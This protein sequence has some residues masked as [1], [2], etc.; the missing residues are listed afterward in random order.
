M[1][2]WELMEGMSNQ[3][4]VHIGLPKTATTSLQLDFFPHVD[5]KEFKYLGVFQFREQRVQDV[6]FQKII[7]AVRSGHDL[8]GANRAL[9]KRLEEEKRS[10][11][12]S[13]E[14]LT[15]GSELKTWQ[16]QLANLSQILAGI[17]AK[18]LV[19]VREP[20]SAMFSFYLELY[21][22]F[23]KSDLCF[24]ELALKNN[25]FAIYRYETL[26][27]VLFECFDPRCIYLQRFEDIVKGNYSDTIQFLGYPEMEVSFS[28]I[29]NHNQKE[30]TKSAVMVSKKIKLKW[31]SDLYQFLGGDKNILALGLKRVV[32]IPIKRL[33]RV[34]VKRISVPTLSENERQLLSKKLQSNMELMEER[35]GIRY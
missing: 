33:R 17:E 32:T 9:K 30:K 28:V 35:F 16:E 10:L 2:T 20:V 7:S 24:S 3:V 11:I 26:F 31:I 13:E 23:E 22:R 1:E 4:Y 27:K 5:N 18:L 12:I 34:T 8:D 19:T 25:D 15:V 21:D 6:L 14:M 29:K